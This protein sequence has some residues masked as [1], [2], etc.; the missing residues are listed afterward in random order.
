VDQFR[1]ATRTLQDRYRKVKQLS[2]GF[3]QIQKETK[4]QIEKQ[5]LIEQ[6][7]TKGLVKEYMKSQR[8]TVIEARRLDREMR[9]KKSAQLKERE[10][11]LQHQLKSQIEIIKEELAEAETQELALRQGEQE[12]RNTSL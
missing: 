6:D 10:E 3:E 1:R 7:L 4:R 2:H 12:V 5:R 8:Q 11:A 9:T